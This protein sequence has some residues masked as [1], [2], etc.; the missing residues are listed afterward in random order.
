M[1]Y[2]TSSVDED[3]GLTEKYLETYFEAVRSCLVIPER[4]IAKASGS[5]AAPS[6]VYTAMHGVGL[7]FASRSFSVFNREPFKSVPSQCE[8]DPTFP[9][10]SFPNPEEKG[11]LDEAMAFAAAE[12]AD[13]VL[14]NDP[15]ADRWALV[16]LRR[17]GKLLYKRR[18][19]NL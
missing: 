6:F 15:D 14:A 2:D 19:A 10:V 13:I 9:T 5:I 17:F 3:V 1:S 8:P 18:K 7:P 12:K 4:P 11:A 16:A